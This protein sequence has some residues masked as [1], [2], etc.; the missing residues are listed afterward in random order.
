MYWI[1]DMSFL[2]FVNDCNFTFNG[3]YDYSTEITMFQRMVVSK[4]G[5]HPTEVICP[6]VLV[7]LVGYRKI[8]QHLQR[9]Y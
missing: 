9:I 5:R 8:I 7:L 1:G 3:E 2:L 6:C 4:G